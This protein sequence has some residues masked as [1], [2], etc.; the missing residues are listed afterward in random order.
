MTAKREA[1]LE[2]ENRMLREQVASLK[3]IT[4]QLIAVV[5]VVPLAVQPS[6]VY[7]PGYSPYWCWPGYQVTCGNLTAS[8]VDISTAALS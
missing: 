6:P 5:P 4:G 8:E 3:E 2:T 1:E 7:V